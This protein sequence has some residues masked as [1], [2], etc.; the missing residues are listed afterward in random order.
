MNQKG[1]DKSSDLTKAL[2]SKGLTTTPTLTKRPTSTR[3]DFN[4]NSIIVQNTEQD[5][6]FNLDKRNGSVNLRLSMR[7]PNELS[8]KEAPNK[9][10][11]LSFSPVSNNSRMCNYFS[12]KMKYSC[13]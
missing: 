1:K 2:F 4:S 10:N 12:I 9:A 3:P 6:F 7:D 5:D 13:C 11:R 8:M